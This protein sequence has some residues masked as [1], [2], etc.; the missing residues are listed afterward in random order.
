MADQ[1]LRLI[2]SNI[3]VGYSVEIDADVSPLDSPHPIDSESE[4][5]FEDDIAD[6]T[7]SDGHGNENGGQYVRYSNLD[8]SIAQFSII[9][10]H[11]SVTSRRFG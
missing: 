10:I 2:N 8:L 11:F 7:V 6:A 1:E 3:D 5:H 4:S 9:Q